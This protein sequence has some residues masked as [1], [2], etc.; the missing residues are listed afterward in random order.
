MKNNAV[1]FVIDGSH[2]A[3]IFMSTNLELVSYIA[4]NILDN[5]VLA[6][7]QSA[8]AE[9]EKY[10]S[11]KVYFSLQKGGK[12]TDLDSRWVSDILRGKIARARMLAQG[13][14][15]LQW[16][17]N[18]ATEAY[19]YTTTVNPD[20]L[21]MAVASPEWFAELYAK[22]TNTPLESAVKQVNFDIDNIRTLRVRRQ[23]LMW[24]Y[25]RSLL[26]VTTQEELDTWKTLVR[27]V[28]TEVGAV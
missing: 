11:R 20:N 23:E 3:V 2:R 27:N 9:A 19:C 1:Y 5:V 22:A 6:L 8:L 15:H 14:T 24:E 18:L 26:D 4:R 10:T 17:A 28:T 25:S 7:P 13:F 21:D 16:F 12:F